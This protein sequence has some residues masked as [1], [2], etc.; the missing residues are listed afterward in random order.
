MLDETGHLIGDFTVATLADP[1][2][3]TESFL[4]LGSGLAEGYHERWFRARLDQARRTNAL[5]GPVEYRPV[6][7]DLTGLSIAGPASREVLAALAD[8]DVSS[9][10]LQ[11]RDVRR[12]DL[13]MVSTLVGR[14]TFT[15]DL[16]YEF[17]VP[18][19]LQQ[20]LFDLLVEAGRPH[21]LRLFG[22]RALDSMRFEKS[23]GAWATEY[24]PIYTPGEAGLDRFVALTA[25]DG[26]DRD[27][28]G[29]EAVVTE[30]AAGP[31]RRLCT[32]VLDDGGIPVNRDA[33]TEVLGDE[34]IWHDGQ[35]VGWATSGG[36]AHWSQ[37][38]CA[39]GYVPADLGDPTASAAGFELEVLGVRRTA[40]RAD[41]PL[42][43]PAGARMR[44]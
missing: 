15:G 40:T 33:G 25:A 41:E 17:W 14:I 6:G 29:R 36:Y 26:S 5:P 32:F 34:P 28:V 20:R 37:A 10:A 18:S 31:P 11:F 1:S 9:D 4:V 12:M 23:F 3:S 22:G 39:L 24:R 42:F 8:A 2:D 19:S 13:G 27:F 38:S 43:D 7:H 30:R 35:V 44:G 16:G 21:G